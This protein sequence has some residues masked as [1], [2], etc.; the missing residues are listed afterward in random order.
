VCLDR[1]EVPG[2]HTAEEKHLIRLVT[3]DF[4]SGNGTGAHLCPE[5][6]AYFASALKSPAVTAGRRNSKRP[7]RRAAAQPA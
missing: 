1:F 4:I 5:C 6:I 7:L 2:H 3:Q